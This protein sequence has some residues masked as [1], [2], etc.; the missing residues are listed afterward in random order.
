[1]ITF[2]IP[3]LIEV[4]LAIFIFATVFTDSLSL[5]L[6]GVKLRKR[7]ASVYVLCQALGYVTNFSLFFILPVIGFV[8]DDVIQ[9]KFQIFILVYAILLIIHSLVYLMFYNFLIK[10][11]HSLI[12]KF[13]NNFR[14]FVMH[15]LFLFSGAK[16]NKIDF[17]DFSFSSLQKLY[18]LSYVVLP[19][20]FPLLLFIGDIFSDYR[21]SFMGLVSL[22][23]GLFSLYIVF[24]IER[25]I[26]ILEPEAR[27]SFVKLLIISKSLAVLCSSL[28]L[29]IYYVVINKG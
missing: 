26:V 14:K 1:M 23:T 8:L 13:S 5:T 21:A 12:Y 15:L 24:V 3:Y 19:I 4:L 7:F 27:A 28:L 10:K 18:F 25:K 9:F 22:Y 11:S 16:R 2:E 29:L 6:K 20:T 17:K